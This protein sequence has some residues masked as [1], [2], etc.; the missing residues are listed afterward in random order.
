MLWF[1][2]SAKEHSVTEHKIQ[3]AN[4]HGRSGGSQLLENLFWSSVVFGNQFRHQK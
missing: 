1:I 4:V 3:C 2:H